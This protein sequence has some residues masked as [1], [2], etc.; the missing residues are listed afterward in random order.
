[1]T[2][3]RDKFPIAVR[4]MRT[5]SISPAPGKATEAF[6]QHSRCRREPCSHPVQRRATS[7][8]MMR[9]QCLK[10]MVRE[11]RERRRIYDEAMRR[12]ASCGFCCE[13]VGGGDR[14]RASVVENR[15][16]AR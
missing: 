5:L 16:R 10:N 12:V 15:Q 13:H 2:S 14:G 6:G 3:I 11:K 8:N 4:R 7:R 9:I 1:M